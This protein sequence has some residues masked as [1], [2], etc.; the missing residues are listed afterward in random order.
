MALNV[1][2]SPMILDGPPYHRHSQTRSASPHNLLCIK[3]LKDLFQIPGRNAHTRI[4][5]G[6]DHIVAFF[7]HMV[8]PFHRAVDISVFH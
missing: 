2:I 6:K 1:D 7:F 5:Y 4:R 8:E 3:G